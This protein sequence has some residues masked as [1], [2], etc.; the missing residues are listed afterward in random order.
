MAKVSPMWLA[1]HG[2]TPVDLRMFKNTTFLY[3]KSLV[4]VPGTIVPL[5][6]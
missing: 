3:G 1:L 5:Q 2:A 4:Y 6:Y